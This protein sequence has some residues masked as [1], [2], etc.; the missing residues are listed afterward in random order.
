MPFVKNANQ[1]SVENNAYPITLQRTCITM[2]IKQLWTGNSYR[3]FNYL[4]VCSET[5]ETA[6]IDP[7]D[8][9]QCLNT[10]KENGW[11]IT[12][13]IN[14]HEHAD[15]IG[16][17]EVVIKSTGASL[18]AHSGS[19]D[20]INGINIGLNDGDIVKLGNTVELEVLNTPGHTMSHVCLLSLGDEK[21]LICGD[22]LFNAGVG[23]CHNGGH[24]EELYSTFK[25]KLALLPDDTKI[26][27]GHEYLSNNLEFT[28]DREP[29]NKKARKLLE[30]A[31]NQDPNSPLVTTLGLEK[32]INTFLRLENPEI[33]E[34]LKI[35]FPNLAENPDPKSIFL[36]LRE[37]RNNW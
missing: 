22:T 2:I 7:L 17:N 18:L 10:A 36:K 16:G 3:N 6:A 8:H 27:P 34:Q 30:T 25:N 28:L 20:S 26:F 4:V 35:S 21:A 33:I 1:L 5:G 23:N 24:P 32:D 9:K 11:N 37:L 13:V 29:S 12:K 31:R 19:K 15:H 14:T